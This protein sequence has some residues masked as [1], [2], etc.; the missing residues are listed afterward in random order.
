[1]TAA[2]SPRPSRFR[3]SRSVRS[4]PQL[5]LLE[6]RLPPG[7]MLLGLAWGSFWMSADSSEG[8]TAMLFLRRPP[9]GVLSQ[10]SQPVGA[11]T[12]VVLVTAGPDSPPAAPP[13]PPGSAT[14]VVGSTP[15]LS[16]DPWLAAFSTA[17]AMSVWSAGTVLAPEAVG[18]M[19]TTPLDHAGV[20]STGGALP[21]AN[22]A[23]PAGLGQWLLE[24]LATDPR[25][26]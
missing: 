25:P 7:D 21:S 16:A 17:Q 15:R 11:D 8:S 2:G 9:A 20:A 18:G 12:L 3:V 13:P 26:T 14:G 1:F 23:T 10:A 4:R 19:V 5:Q 22:S 24:A 6:D